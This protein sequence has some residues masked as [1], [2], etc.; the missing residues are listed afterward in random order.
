MTD[1]LARD[2]ADATE[3][4]RQAAREYAAGAEYTAEKLAGL[5]VFARIWG[6]EAEFEVAF[7]EAE[8]IRKLEASTTLKEAEET[9]KFSAGVQPKVE[10]EPAAQPRP[11]RGK[12]PLRRMP[13]RRY[14]N[15]R[16]EGEEEVG[17]RA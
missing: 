2:K 8:E 15:R 14:D 17:A 13:W 12:F 4:L 5:E 10:Q 9:K 1:M 6:L 16:V 3:K 7:R 11:G